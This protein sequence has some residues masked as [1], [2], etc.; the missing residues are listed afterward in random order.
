M[1]RAGRL[2]RKVQ[3]KDFP[4]TR[5]V[6][7][8]REKAHNALNLHMVE[9]LHRA[10]VAD[11]H[12]HPSSVVV[13]KGAGAK[14]FCAGGDVVSVVK[15]EPSGTRQAFFFKEY[16]VN[17]HL[18][19]SPNTQVSLWNGIVMGG[20]VG[21]SIHGKYRVATEQALFAMPET[22]I[23]L[24]P[25][26]GGSWFL[27]RL[28]DKALGLYLA[29][30]GRRL[31]GADLVHAGLATHYVPAEKLPVLEAQLC[32]RKSTDD[33]GAILEEFSTAHHNLPGFSLAGDL[34]LLDSAFHPSKSVEEMVATL[35]SDGSELAMSLADHMVNKCSPTSL[36]LS[37][38]LFRRGAVMDD[39]ADIFTM[40]Y[41]AT[42]AAMHHGD[43]ATGVTALLIDKTNKPKWNPATLEE[44]TPEMIE[45]FF[46]PATPTTPKWAP[47]TTYE[48]AV[49][50]ATPA[51]A[52]ASANKSP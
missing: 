2:L 26:V 35:R 45:A 39:P 33:V 8:D 16:T 4:H 51:S 21:M 20:G 6:T 25:D 30:T 52:S 31:K 32:E 1:F 37:L 28:P 15:D 48:A 11:P 29:L 49:A 36:K 23:G 14:A 41:Y 43:F 44:V 12:P 46:K 47:G 7:L 34:K 18:L 50:A 22:G 19:T 9:E 5:L 42:Q 10:L 13:L 27:P 17:H 3:V 40:E 38:E 24:F